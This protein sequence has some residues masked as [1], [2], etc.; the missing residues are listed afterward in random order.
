ME[1]VFSL[2]RELRGKSKGKISLEFVA[3]VGFLLVMYVAMG[4][5]GLWLGSPNVHALI[6]SFGPLM[7]LAYA[8]LFLAT[9]VIAPLPGLPLMAMSVEIF[10][11]VNAIIFSYFLALI[12]AALNF[13]I[14]R[15]WGRPVMRWLVGKRGLKKIDRHTEEFSVEVLVLTRLFDGLLFEWISYAAGLTKINFSKYMV[16]TALCSLP[17]FLIF[18]VISASSANLGQLFVGL[19][20]VNSITMSFPFLYFLAKGIVAKKTRHGLV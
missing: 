4:K 8:I 12:G 10:G 11:F 20:L 1:N 2:K 14:A 19:C 5:I 15:L 9:L 16:I 6:F 18:L 17:Y 7:P 13:Y 3:V